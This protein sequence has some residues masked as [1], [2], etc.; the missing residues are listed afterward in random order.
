MGATAPDSFDAATGV[1]NDGMEEV[2]VDWGGCTRP[3]AV[4]VGASEVKSSGFERAAICCFSSPYSFHSSICSKS[5][6]GEPDQNEQ[7]MRKACEERRG[8][9][10]MR[11]QV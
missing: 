11:R 10:R 3:A 2:L 5:C 9:K 7:H 8:K 1:V 4:D 6:S